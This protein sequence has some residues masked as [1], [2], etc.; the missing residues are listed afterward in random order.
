LAVEKLRNSARA[1]GILIA[2]LR[3]KEASRQVNRFDENRRE[4][5]RL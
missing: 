1:G 4:K 3:A 5:F 2:T